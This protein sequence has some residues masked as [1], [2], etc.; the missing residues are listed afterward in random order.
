VTGFVQDRP[1]VQGF[2][3]VG[4]NARV[5]AFATVLSQLL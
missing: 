5:D 4:V 3:I 1:E 2:A